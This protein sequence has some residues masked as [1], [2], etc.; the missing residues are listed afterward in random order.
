ME[1]YVNHNEDICM[2]IPIPEEPSVNSTRS[3]SR[4]NA[5]GCLFAILFIAIV[6]AT[7]YLTCPDAAAHKEKLSHVVVGAVNDVIDRKLGPDNALI[8]KGIQ[9][10]G[11][12]FVEKVADTAVNSLLTVDNYGV[13]SIGKISYG[14]EERLVSLGI[15]G[16][17]I[18]VD[19]STVADAVEQ[20]QSTIFTTSGR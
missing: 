16:N 4:H 19:Q 15:F 10:I 8:A 20:Y 14:G 17:I 12:S 6:T 2:G 5:G 1:N 18:T 11:N 3:S 7:M 9:M 13:C